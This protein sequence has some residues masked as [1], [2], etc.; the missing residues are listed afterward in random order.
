[1]ESM[2]CSANPQSI[3][4]VFRPAAISLLTGPLQPAGQGGQIAA[5]ASRVRQ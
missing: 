1:M 4:C 3:K 2:V 5:A